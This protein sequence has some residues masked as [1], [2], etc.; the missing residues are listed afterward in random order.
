MTRTELIAFCKANKIG[1]I[2]RLGGHLNAAFL[3][4]KEV[5]AYASIT[6]R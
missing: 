6:L 2:K 5:A 1:D 3:W 4:C